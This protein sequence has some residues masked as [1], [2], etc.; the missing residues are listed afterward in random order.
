MLRKEFRIFRNYYRDYKCSKNKQVKLFNTM[1]Y[2]TKNYTNIMV[3]KNH[4]LYRFLVN[5]INVQQYTNKKIAI[6]GSGRRKTFYLNSHPIKI[7]YTAENNHVQWSVWQECEDMLL[8]EKSLSLSLGFDYI[9]HPKYLRFPYWLMAHFSP[10]AT[11]ED[12]K[13]WCD[14]INNPN[15]QNRDKFCAF[16]CRN[17]YFGDRKYFLNEVNQI[18]NVN[19]PGSFM[20]NDDDLKNK[21][22]DNKSDYLRQFKFNLCPEN[23]DNM[24]YVTEKIFDA[25]KAGCIPIYWG[26]ENNPEPDVLNKDAIIFLNHSSYYTIKERID[27]HNEAALKKI[28]ELKN[29]LKL[30]RDF[31]MQPRLHPDAPE[32]IYEYFERLEKKLIEIVKV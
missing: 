4:W 22:N 20:H 27:F 13:K 6:F 28:S 19:C 11:Y 8:N 26:A 25:H 9:D 31:S 10:E 17:D 30:Y 15:I 23:S 2:D 7:Y 12:I 29:N 24:G 1:I 14:E 32:I 18:S 5:R 3:L 21:F 16:I